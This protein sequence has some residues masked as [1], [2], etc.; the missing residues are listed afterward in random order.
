MRPYHFG[1]EAVMGLFGVFKA[2]NELERSGRWFDLPVVR[3]DDGTVP[4]FKMARMHAN[5]PAYQAAL[6]RVSDDIQMAMETGTL[7]EATAGPVMR[8][9]FLDTILLDWRNVI[10]DTGEFTGTKGK[11]IPFN[12]ENADKLLV[13]VPDLFQILMTEAKKLGNFRSKEVEKIAGEL[14]P[15]SEQS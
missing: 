7:N 12:R 10:D 13:L 4:G 9:V 15:Q 2:N 5:N 6:E 14:Q 1:V 11:A 3:N 8:G